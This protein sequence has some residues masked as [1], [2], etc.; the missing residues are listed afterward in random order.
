M[1]VRGGTI[2]NFGTAIR[3][4]EGLVVEQMRVVSNGIGVDGGNAGS[5]VVKDSVFSDNNNWG[6]SV[7]AGV[8]TGNSFTRNGTA[9][10]SGSMSSYPPAGSSVTIA[11][12]AF[13]QNNVGI[14][15]SGP[16]SIQNNMIEGG[17]N[18]LSV[19]CPARVTGNTVVR[20]GTPV[21][22]QNTNVWDCTFEHNSIRQF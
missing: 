5:V 2:Y 20:A 3:G 6:V 16:A 13:S 21:S 17:Y 9:V 18:A 10:M 19:A 1:V 11:N 22:F 12:N 8:V 7:G 15:T 4:G 14:Q